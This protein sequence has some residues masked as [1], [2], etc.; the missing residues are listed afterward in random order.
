MPRVTVLFILALLLL[1]LVRADVSLPPWS[2]D[3]YTG[4]TQW[5]VT[6]SDDE[7]GCESGVIVTHPTITIQFNQQHAQMGDI[8]HGVA[9]G[10]VNGNVLHIPGRSVPDGYGTS[11][12]S[13]YDIT[14]TSDCLTF[15]GSYHWDYSD[16]AGSCSGSTTLSGRIVNG[17]P[18]PTVVIPPSKPPELTEEEQLSDAHHDLNNDF[19]LRNQ[20]PYLKMQ[21]L[22]LNTPQTAAELKQT[23]DH[24]DN[25][26]P[27]VEAKYNAILKADP[28]NFEA[29]VAMAELKKSQGLPH[30]YYEYM[31]RAINSGAVT[32]SMKETMEK[33]L[34]KELGFSTFPK[35]AN[36]LLMRKVGIEKDP[37]QGSLYDMDV[38]KESSD[39]NTWSAKIF[40]SLGL[41]SDVVNA[42]AV[43]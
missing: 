37:W 10:I 33:N 5:S 40:F 34:A 2:W 28:N 12:L 4:T 8:G 38:K 29:N 32:E 1:H 18:A 27:S 22:L 30:E 25:L 7:R 11:V 9:S 39:K 42:V 23:Q 16:S 15:T 13:P 43:K 36:S 17:C 6:V 3:Q 35:P 19:H 24:I 31:D 20:I 41:N 14:F 26:E 21:N